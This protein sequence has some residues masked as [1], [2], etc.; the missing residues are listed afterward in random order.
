M[1]GCAF[2]CIGT[3]IEFSRFYLCL[4]VSVPAYRQM[5]AV[6]WVVALDLMMIRLPGSVAVLSI[7]SMLSGEY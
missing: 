6:S 3:V 5:G 1:L 7:G 4:V 2:P